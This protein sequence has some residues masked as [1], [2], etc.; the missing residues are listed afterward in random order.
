[1]L[2]LAIRLTAALVAL[3]SASITGDM[4]A[5]LNQNHEAAHGLMVAGLVI[6]VITGVFSLGIL[7]AGLAPAFRRLIPSHVRR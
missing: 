3:A 2:V 6:V 1:M 5:R 4:V 7:A